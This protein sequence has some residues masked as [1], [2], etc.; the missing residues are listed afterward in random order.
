M[1]NGM[2]KV[3]GLRT[4]QSTNRSSTGR[5]FLSPLSRNN[6]HL[7]QSFDF[8]Q[9]MLQRSH[10]EATATPTMQYGQATSPSTPLFNSADA[11]RNG[12]TLQDCTLRAEEELTR[13]HDALM[14]FIHEK[15]KKDM[16][17][18]WM[19]TQNRVRSAASCSCYCSLCR[20]AI[21]LRIKR[22]GGMAVIGNEC[23]DDEKVVD[24]NELEVRAQSSN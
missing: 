11:T 13:L 12:P 17:G 24:A 21:E 9:L 8:S 7:S 1:V 5:R 10:S 20:Q 23:K 19:Q 16:H 22:F 14:C 18:V 15:R 4:L 3:V 2:K 6:V